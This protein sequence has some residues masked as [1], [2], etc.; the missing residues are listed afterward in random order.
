LYIK[1]LFTHSTIINMTL[2]ENLN[3]SQPNPSTLGKRMLI[4]GGIALA[5][6]AVFVF[7]AGKGKPEWGSYW[8][9]KPLI[10]TPLIGAIAGA[11]TYKL[12]QLGWNKTLT[13]ILNII[14]YLVAL[15]IGIVLGLN[16]TMWD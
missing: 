16:G 7:G 9:V 5:V 10:L 3:P 15:W 1:V 11:C 13:V 6:I 8:M 12:D 14:G 2:S 4:G